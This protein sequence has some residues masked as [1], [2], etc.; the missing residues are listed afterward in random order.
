MDDGIPSSNFWSG[1]FLHIP[2]V[3]SQ[4]FL[5]TYGHSAEKQITKSNYKVKGCIYNADGEEGIVVSAPNGFTYTFNEVKTYYNGAIPNLHMPRTYTKIL[6]V[7]KIEDKYGNDVIYNYEDGDLISI[8]SSD[9]RRIDIDYGVVDNKKRPV[10]AS[11][12]NRVWE[13]HYN[14]S[15]GYLNKV[16]LPNGTTWEYGGIHILGYRGQ[17]PSFFYTN[18]LQFYNRNKGRSYGGQKI[19]SCAI[20]HPEPKEVT[21][22]TPEGAIIRYT[23]QIKKHNRSNVIPRVYDYQ[24]LDE[25]S[26]MYNLNCSLS[27]SLVRKRITGSKLDDIDWNY[28]YSENSGHY[29]LSNRPP[30]YFDDG[31]RNDLND[32]VSGPVDISKSVGIEKFPSMIA[33]RTPLHFR[34]VKII[35]QDK[36]N[37]LYI[38]RESQSISENMVIAEDTLSLSNQLIKREEY[39]YS[40]GDFVGSSWVD[41]GQ[42]GSPCEVIN[43]SQIKNRVNLVNKKIIIYNNNYKDEYLTDFE[44][45]DTYGFVTEIRERNNF[46]N[47]E[48]YNKKVYLHDNDSWVLGLPV[49]EFTDDKLIDG[50]TIANYEI[51]YKNFSNY[52]NGKNNTFK[53]PTLQKKRGVI[54]INAR[55]Y[56]S[57]G[58]LKKV[59]YNLNRTYGT[60][61]RFIEYANYKRGL[62]QLI[63]VPN[64]STS[65]NMSASR[66]VDNNGWVTRTTDYNGIST[67]YTYDDIGRIKSVDLTNDAANGNWYDTL[68]TW[69]NDTNTRTASTCTLNNSRTA[70]AGNAVFKTTE[71]YDSLLRLT[72]IK[73]QDLV[74]SSAANSTRY[75]RFEYNY[76]N[77]PTFQSYASAN[78]SENKGTTTVYDSL[79][80]QQSVTTSG[81]GTV[82]YAYLSGNRIEVTDAKDNVTTT[83]YQAFGSPSY[84][85]AVKIE[86]PEDVTT[87]MDVDIF[88]LTHSIT[89]TAANQHGNTV[90]VTE[91]RYYDNTKKLCLTT[92]PDVGNTIYKYNALGELS[93]HKASVNNTQC[94]TTKPVGATNYTYD[95]L[96]GLKYVNYPDNSGDV[97]YERDNN[98]NVL[99]LTAGDV[100]H[101]YTYNN[102]NLLEEEQLFVGN[103]L[104]LMLSYKYNAL[105]QRKQ[106]GYPDGTIVNFKPNGFGEPTEVQTYKNGAVE[107][108]FAK[109]AKYYAN[110]MLDSFTYGNGVTHKTTLYSDSLLPKQLKDTG[111]A[112]SNL[113]STV[114]ALT[115]DYDN[116][117]N[118][119]SII[120]GQNSAHS[121]TY[122]GYDD[123]D[124]LT[125]TT[126]GTGIGSSTLRYDG[127]GN[128]TYYKNK[129]KTLNY[130][131]DYAKNRLSKVTGVSGRYG[132]IGYDSRGNITN[133][134][135]YSLD[136][137]EA[138][139]LTTA[140]GNSYLYDGHN[141]RVKQTDGNGTSYSMYSQDGMLLYREKGST[142]TGNGTNYIYLGK[143]LIAK[144]GDVTPQTVSESRQ[145]TRPFGE[146]IEAPKD[147]VGYTGHKFDTDLG[148][149]YMQAR[150]YDPVIGRFYSNDPVD[151]L[152]HMGRG[153]PV[154]GFGRYT[155][156]NNNPYKYTD[157]NGE[158]PFL[159]V[160]A[161]VIG[162]AIGA[163]SEAVTNENASF[164]SVMKAGGVG[165]A[166]GVATTFGG[167]LLGTMAV[168]AGA[169]G[170][171]E[172]ANQAMDGEFNTEDVI[173]AAAIGAVGG[174]VAKTAAKVAVAGRGLPNNSATQASNN[175]TG[176]NSQRILADSKTL[177]TTPGNR[178]V[179]EVK[180]GGAYGTGAA[181][182]AAHQQTQCNDDSC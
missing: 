58:L 138:N 4:R 154:H 118:I 64:R 105:Q 167:G 65:G 109:D 123:L 88:G 168:G 45:F 112:G 60:G 145:H 22:K 41:C 32:F 106:L 178:A 12:N 7:S 61:K 73:S 160:G 121:S 143:K 68:Y 120:D 139:Q 141:R 92:R 43:I 16:I 158:F 171:G 72:E 10:S 100:T 39:T 69:N 36:I 17:N 117:A 28:I 107:L 97:S 156:A 164:G 82:N 3:T 79:G 129:G 176:A 24:R 1:K 140:K 46:S 35:K 70:C 63:T 26:Y 86:S 147:D 8:V 163:I 57:S 42:R 34:T 47:N 93:W 114:M 134:G 77:Q 54:F 177:S 130:T 137:N 2:N 30:F 172:V 33:S 116:N 21:V 113:P 59:S 102:Q 149:S 55:E 6:M 124:R 179:A 44:K 85:Q 76:L 91:H 78:V 115:Y 9:G 14:T 108:S 89:Q 181:A 180:L 155:Y 90:S 51:E 99:T 151:A 71:Y 53:L 25:F 52:K 146:S 110:G 111:P 125:S 166:V 19:P 131:Y 169:N 104:P 175:M 27:L 144:Y 103:Q 18:Q 126:G 152:G 37:I 165:A 11:V 173:E 182:E 135:A 74:N 127:F 133:N 29:G 162:F 81:L 98:G 96:G 153:N 40:K 122:L 67:N 49:S 56:F 159:Q 161:G 31:E 23:L 174:A 20:V 128:I 48:I 66:V 15:D 95:N 50:S 148:L 101:R 119:T 80:R 5:N 157:P 142:I 84:S 83:T 62:P 136:F 13:Y 150:Y 132:S 87:Q 94:S 170:L 38:D 75:Q